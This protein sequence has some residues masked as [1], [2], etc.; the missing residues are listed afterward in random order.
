MWLTCKSV[1]S[2]PGQSPPQRGWTSANLFRA[3]REK[4]EVSEDESILP[5]DGLGI[6]R[7]NITSC[8]NFQTDSQPADF[9]LASS[10]Y[11]CQFLKN[12]NMCIFTQPTG[13]VSLENPNKYSTLSCRMISWQMITMIITPTLECLLCARCF[14]WTTSC[15]P[16]NSS[17]CWAVFPCFTNEEIKVSW[18]NSPRSES[19]RGTV[20][21]S[22]FPGLSTQTNISEF[23]WQS[24]F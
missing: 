1:H 7:C 17:M 13:S 8:W 5:P 4:A 11:N 19:Y 23:L 3:W 14:S 20:N 10:P 16:H 21:G 24:I 22:R 15:N 6:R 9:G 2:E 12:P 18:N